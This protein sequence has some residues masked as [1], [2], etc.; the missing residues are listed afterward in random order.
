MSETIVV[1][2]DGSDTSKNALRWAARQAEV[3]RAT[4]V[5]VYSWGPIYPVG[6]DPEEK[7]RKELRK[8]V[9][10][11]LGAGPADGVRLV[12][13]P[14]APGHLLV[15]EAA[16]AELLVVGGHGHGHGALA[17]ALVGSVIEYCLHHARCPVAVIPVAERS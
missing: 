7:A 12:L 15:R 4:L 9:V 8:Q 5:A 1:G 14:D 2:V 10:Q 3:T 17:S 13:S 11:V 6:I 16:Q